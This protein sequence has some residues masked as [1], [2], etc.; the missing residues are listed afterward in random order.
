MHASPRQS[1]AV[2]GFYHV[3][4]RGVN[5]EKIFRTEDDYYYFLE[6]IPKALEL[7]NVAVHGFTLMP[8]HVHFI[9]EQEMPYAIS[10]FMKRV[11]ETFARTV[12]HVHRRVGHLFQGRFKRKYVQSINY[13]LALAR[14]VDL[15]PVHSRL[16]A[17]PEEWRFGSVRNYLSTETSSYLRTE[18]ILGLVGGKESYAAYLNRPPEVLGSE[19]EH[20]LIDRELL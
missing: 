12:N 8:N 15:N 6:L 10:A 4:N 3:Y 7:G 18:T 13:L 9:L 19:I 5:R 17:T 14:Y 2:P 1:L 20:L 16:V 11:S